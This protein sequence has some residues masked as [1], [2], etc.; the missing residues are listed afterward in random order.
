MHWS[1]FSCGMPKELPRQVPRPGKFDLLCFFF[2]VLSVFYRVSF[3]F[4]LQSQHFAIFSMFCLVFQWI[5]LHFALNYWFSFEK[6]MKTVRKLQNA[7][8]VPKIPIKP[9]KK[10]VKPL[11]KPN[12]TNFPGSGDLPG[13][14][15]PSQLS[16]A[17]LTN[18]SCQPGLG[19]QRTQA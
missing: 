12:K 7:V 19:C 11:K 10:P 17:S 18:W 6:T 16:P 4:L 8:T 2:W 14:A 13:S 9:N 3:V 1:G 5:S 15:Q